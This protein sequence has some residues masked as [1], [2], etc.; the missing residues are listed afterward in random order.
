MQPWP[1]ALRKCFS[2]FESKNSLAEEK[3]YKKSQKR[4]RTS[5][6]STDE[7]DIE[8]EKIVEKDPASL[9]ILGSPFVDVSLGQTDAVLK[10]LQCL[11]GK[12]TDTG[13]TNTEQQFDNFLPPEEACAWVQCDKKRCR[14]WRRVPWNVNIE[15]LPQIWDCSMIYWD[16]ENATCDAQQDSYD[17]NRESTLGF[18]GHAAELINFEINS[19]RD[20]FCVINQFFYEAQVKA[21]KEGTDEMGKPCKLIKFHFKGWPKNFDEWIPIGSPRIA[22]HNLHT[23]PNANNRVEQEKLQ[24]ERGFDHNGFRLGKSTKKIAI[25]ENIKGKKTTHSKLP[26]T[27][28]NNAYDLSQKLKEEQERAKIQKIERENR[29]RRQQEVWQEMPSELIDAYPSVV[30]VAANVDSRFVDVATNA[31]EAHAGT[32]RDDASTNPKVYNNANSTEIPF[33]KIAVLRDII[34]PVATDIVTDISCEADRNVVINPINMLCSAIAA[35][36]KSDQREDQL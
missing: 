32:W 29:L 36:K 17:P 3:K 33:T 22:P 24:R 27:S 31:D 23:D 13:G 35:V 26:I 16:P 14:K 30:D 12:S 15:S 19:W 34:V 21:I 6:E 10:A 8:E 7:I 9:H 18:E 2:N 25:H 11:S 5:N 20:V 4:K 1:D 28:R